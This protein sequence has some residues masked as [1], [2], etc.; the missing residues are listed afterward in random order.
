M[1]QPTESSPPEPII[2][3]V[4]RWY[5]KRMAMM[6]GMLSL[7][8]LYFIYD[9]KFGYPKAN[10]IADKKTWFEQV[11][12]KTFDEAKTAGKLDAWTAAAK[13]QDWPTGRESEP[14]RWISF[15]AKNSWPEKPH[16]YTQ[17]E[18]DG[19]FWWGGGTLVIALGVGILVL[20]NK[21]KVLKAESDHLVTPDGKT[22]F[23]ADAYRV[24]KRLWDNKALAYIWHKPEGGKETRA[25]IDDLKYEG[26]GRVLD[27][28]MLH[29][30]GELIE[31]Q[32]DPTDVPS[33]PTSE[34][35]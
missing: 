18:I 22:V 9:G 4:T 27:R 17:E 1:D 23:Y 5:F 31:K 25:V 14:P 32:A 30:K 35:I 16:R 8:G 28:L 29:F 11:V 6:A 2:C 13:A 26:A 33:E 24:D 21:N 7:F 3:R 19:Q 12:L 15:A 34:S 10:E 20:L